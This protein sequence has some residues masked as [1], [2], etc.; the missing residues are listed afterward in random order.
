MVAAPLVEVTPSQ[1]FAS[2]PPHMTIV[3]WFD[4]EADRWQQ[5]DAVLADD[6]MEEERFH[7]VHGVSRAMFGAE[8][9]VAVTRLAGCM[10]GM[11]AAVFSLAKALG[12]TFDERYLGLDWAPHVADK[13]GSCVAP[14]QS[15]ELSVLAVFQSLPDSRVVKAVYR[16]EDRA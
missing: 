9:N 3:P 14:G 16:W 5:F 6:I 7:A 13:P 4:L 1:L 11:H 2:L 8:H 10:F 15:L 12:A